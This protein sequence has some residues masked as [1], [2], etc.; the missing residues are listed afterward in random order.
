[1]RAFSWERAGLKWAFEGGG[2]SSLF[3]IRGRRSALLRVRSGDCVR[4]FS[5]GRWRVVVVLLCLGW[6][7][8]VSEPS[9]G[10]ER[11]GEGA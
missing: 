4:T 3:W 1:V 6:L 7:R 10:G 8:G 9:H 5:W 11:A 2:R